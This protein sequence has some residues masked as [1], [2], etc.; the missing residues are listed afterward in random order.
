MKFNVSLSDIINSK[1]KVK[2]IKF[3]LVHEADM[4]ER[5]IASVLKISHM[6]VNRTLRKL[7]AINFAN[8]ITIG[9][10]HL[11]RMNRKSY[12]FKYFSEF[13]NN[14]SGDETP[15]EDLEKSILKNLPKTFIKK[16]VL[17]GS[18]AQGAEKINSDI[19]IFILVKNMRDKRK[20]EPF[21]EK[22][23]NL[24]FEIYGNRLSPYILTE[25]R[26]EQK[27]NTPLISEIN[28]GIQIFPK[29]K[30]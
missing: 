12:A 8:F 6:S 14:I 21:I 1:T 27:K 26:L 19:D 25:N 22:L 3:L 24:C 13:I 23:S 18:V 10:S 11:W 7:S 16:V 2:I 29:K 28:K 5:E 15:L 17:F 9:K 30:R 20:L 4:S